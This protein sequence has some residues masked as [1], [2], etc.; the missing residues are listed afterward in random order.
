MK[1]LTLLIAGLFFFLCQG[2]AMAQT[3]EITVSHECSSEEYCKKHFSGTKCMPGI[4]ASAKKWCVEPCGENKTCA[5]GFTCYDGYCRFKPRRECTSSPSV[6]NAF[7]GTT[8]V[9]GIFDPSRKWCATPCG[10]DNK[11]EKKG[12]KCVDGYCHPKKWAH[13]NNKKK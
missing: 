1:S 4:I 5:S 8:C 3:K 13:P 7:P 10:K 12:F 6:C 2:N 11:C 9:V